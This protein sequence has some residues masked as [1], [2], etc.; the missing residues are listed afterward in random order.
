M[1]LF[2]GELI[3]NKTPAGSRPHKFRVLRD[4]KEE[5]LTPAE[6]IDLLRMSDR[7]MIAKGGNAATTAAF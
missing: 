4:G 1:P 5:Y 6:F 2:T 7:I 3:L